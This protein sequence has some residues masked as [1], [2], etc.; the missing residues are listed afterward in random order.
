[1][2]RRL[3][4]ALLLTSVLMISG[5][6]KQDDRTDFEEQPHSYTESAEKLKNLG[7][8]GITDELIQNLQSDYAQLPPDVEFNKTANLLTAVGA[9]TF[10]AVT[11]TWTPA[12][13][14]VYCFDIEIYNLDTM[15]TDFLLGVSSLDK[16]T[17]NFQNII[18]DTS[19]VN[20]EEGTGKRTVSFTWNG[21]SY[22]L[23]A[24]MH[25]DWFDVN[26]ANELGKIIKENS[27]DKKLFFADDGYQE[28]IVFYR[29]K[30]WADSFQKETGL[31]LS[32]TP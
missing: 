6:G 16:E 22:L 1:M 13:N 32:P 15:Y 14:G 31:V 25:N 7:I 19:Q 28:C 11:G 4:S 3:L 23:E 8:T 30:E 27:K 5:C 26:V 9:G 10:D 12:S 2:K 24:E 18:E 21:K 20:W 17:L 29:D